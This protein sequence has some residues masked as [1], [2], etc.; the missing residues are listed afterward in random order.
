MKVILFEWKPEINVKTA[1][2]NS[3]KTRREKDPIP[4]AKTGK[5]SLYNC[6]RT[7]RSHDLFDI[8]GALEHAPML[9]FAP[10]ARRAT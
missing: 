6:L 5:H 7:G 10:I 2:G 1:I 9:Q 4:G 3:Q 8:T